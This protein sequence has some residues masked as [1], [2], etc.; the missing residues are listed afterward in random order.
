MPVLQYG[1]EWREQRK[2]AHVALSPA[3]VKNYHS[4][5]EDHAAKLS[6]QLLDSPL[7]FFDH[8]RL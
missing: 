2:L 8:A 3:A 1:D 7:E 4:I 5:Q 6:K